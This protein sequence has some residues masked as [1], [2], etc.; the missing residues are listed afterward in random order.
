MTAPK[1]SRIRAWVRA[2]A[3]NVRTLVGIPDY[4]HYLAHMARH[5]PGAVVMTEREFHARAIDRR[6]GGSRP[7]CC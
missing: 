7:R 2:A 6:Y 3:R 5:H 1:T 4:R